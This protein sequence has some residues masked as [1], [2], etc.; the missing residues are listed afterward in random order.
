MKI[1]LH[2]NRLQLTVNVNNGRKQTLSDR[3]CNL[4]EKILLHRD[5]H[6]KWPCCM[7]KEELFEVLTRVYTISLLITQKPIITCYEIVNVNC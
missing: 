2:Q 6:Q 5:K 1:D 4:G 7:G 3:F